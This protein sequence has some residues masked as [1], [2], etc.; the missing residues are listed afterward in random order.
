MTTGPLQVNR[1]IVL[2]MKRQT[3]KERQSRS[4][5]AAII[6]LA[7][8]QPHPRDVMNYV[9]DDKVTVIGQ[10]TRTANLY[11]PVAA[12]MDMI[13]EGAN[14][15]AFYTD[16]A[17]YGQDL[18]DLFLVSRARRSIPV[19]YQNYVVSE[20]HVVGVRVADASGITI[21]SSLLDEKI[22]RATT[23]AAQRW[24]FTVF[25]QVETQ[26]QLEVA[27]TLSPHVISYG[28]PLS[29]QV[30]KALQE[31]PALRE[32]IPHHTKLMLSHTLHTLDEAEAA[33]KA[34]VRGMIVAPYL[35]KGDNARKLRL[36]TG[37]EVR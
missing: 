5:M 23:I 7:H 6:S 18:E 14:A 13:Y 12:A 32:Q 24:R 9:D 21:H 11:D 20:Y 3:I 34:G 19:I 1:D 29:H 25:V 17:V 22:V 8:M 26:A 16:H 37:Q 33:V 31:L 10:V 15:I 30:S 4:P 2:A 35:L 28:D 27:N 36:L